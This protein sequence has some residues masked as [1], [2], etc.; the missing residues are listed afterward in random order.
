M[1]Q[2]SSIVPQENPRDPDFRITLRKLRHELAECRRGARSLHRI[3]V[4]RLLEALTEELEA[5]DW[6]EEMTQRLTQLQRR[7]RC[8]GLT[9]ANCQ[10]LDIVMERIRR[11]ERAECGAEPD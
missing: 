6:A 7:V 11:F 2:K 4:N 8:N 9:V 10:D 3:E 1:G 5:F